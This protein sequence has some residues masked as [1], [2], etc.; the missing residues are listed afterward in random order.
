MRCIEQHSYTKDDYNV[1]FEISF[2]SYKS[3][4][5]FPASR[6]TRELGRLPPF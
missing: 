4:S 5:P 1:V 6:S 2:T 3:F